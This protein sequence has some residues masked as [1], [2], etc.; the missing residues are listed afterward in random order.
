MYGLSNKY[1]YKK[2]KKH[3]KQGYTEKFK[4]LAGVTGL[5]TFSRKACSGRRPV[6][7]TIGRYMYTSLHTERYTVVQILMT[8]RQSPSNVR[9]QNTPARAL[10]AC[11]YR[12]MPLPS[13]RTVSITS[14]RVLSG[15]SLRMAK[16][17]CPQFSESDNASGD[18]SRLK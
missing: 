18:S 15:L 5:D 4:I 8:L 6:L 11:S 16:V 3:R 10:A 2:F 17:G 12:L 1:R 13:H 7:G 9:L 14:Q